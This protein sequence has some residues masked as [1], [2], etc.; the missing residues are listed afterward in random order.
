M[1]QWIPNTTSGLAFE[2]EVYVTAWLPVFIH[3]LF[4]LN[5]WFYESIW[6]RQ[7]MYFGEHCNSVNKRFFFLSSFVELLFCIESRWP[8]I[9]FQ[10]AMVLSSLL[11]VRAGNLFHM[12]A[13]WY[14]VNIVV[15]SARGLCWSTHYWYFLWRFNYTS[16]IHCSSSNACC[17]S[18]TCMGNN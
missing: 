10:L 5:N 2:M 6:I 8:I 16:I 3:K 14:L 13:W 1:T 9:W 4:R 15:I 12:S 18:R 17:R 7:Q 11:L